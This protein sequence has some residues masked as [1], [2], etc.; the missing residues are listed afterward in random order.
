[1]LSLPVLKQS[2]YVLQCFEKG[3]TK[4][5]IVKLLEDERSLAEA[6]LIYFKQMGCVQET[7]GKWFLS[8]RGKVTLQLLT[9]NAD[10]KNK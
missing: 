6:Y 2:A 3:L 10:R 1:M 5:E 7:S 9:K 4:E 8:Q